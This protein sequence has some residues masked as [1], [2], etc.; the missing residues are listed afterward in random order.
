MEHCL[1]L[2]VAMCLHAAPQME[3]VPQV[4]ER[5]RQAVA[6]QCEARGLRLQLLDALSA[7]LGGNRPLEV[8]GTVKHLHIAACVDCR[9]QYVQHT[10]P[11]SGTVD[12]IKDC[13]YIDAHDAWC[14]WLPVVAWVL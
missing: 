1:N 3:Y 13:A 14:M 8:C 12:S 4:S 11:Y 2:G 10:K 9:V 6:T 7:A 5:V